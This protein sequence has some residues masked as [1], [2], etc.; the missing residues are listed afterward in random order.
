MIRTLLIAAGM[1]L[2][3]SYGAGAAPVVLNHTDSLG[4]GSSPTSETQFLVSFDLDDFQSNGSVLAPS[5]SFDAFGGGSSMFSV[6]FRTDQIFAGDV[7]GNGAQA[8]GI[9]ATPLS[10][11]IGI[12]LSSNSIDVFLNDIQQSFTVFSPFNIDSLPGAF[13]FSEWEFEL[14]SSNAIATV[15]NVSLTQGVSAPSTGGG[16]TPLPTPAGLPLVLFGF[17]ALMA[18]R[19]LRK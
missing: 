2:A 3:S 12:D 15:D 9:P 4:L 1:M 14:S 19:R 8:A 5:L 18:A 6:N 16:G 11:D 13:G 7:F 10:I 17:A